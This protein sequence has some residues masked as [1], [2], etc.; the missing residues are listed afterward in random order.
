MELKK[1]TSPLFVLAT[2]VMAIITLMAIW[3]IYLLLG[4]SSRLVL[5][6]GSSGGINFVRL[7]L[8]EGSTFILLLSFVFVFFIV[9]F[10][11]D[12]KKNRSIHSFFA[13]LTHEL[14]TPLASIR[15]QSE[16]I[17][18]EAHEIKNERL[19]KLSKRLISD[20]IRLEAQMDNI[21]QLSRIERGGNLN[22]SSYNVYELIQSVASLYKDN[23]TI[24]INGN[25]EAELRCDRFAFE[26]ILK[27]LFE[28]TKNHTSTKKI[29]IDY[30]SHD[31]FTL[32]NYQD[33]GEF[34]GDVKK[35]GKLFYK[36]NSQKGSG[37]GLY[38]SN[39]LIESMNG[40][41]EIHHNRG[42]KFE[43]KFLT[44]KDTH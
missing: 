31:Q 36:F 7:I 41:L 5:L 17:N 19:E 22:I 12:M 21:L 39:K 8:W 2:I 9:L 4:M 10:Y 26:I 30:K 35:L 27:N 3:W 1:K 44:A 42:L 43:L 11:K 13:S 32:I 37:I 20:T 24:I 38:L 16:V 33:E 25:K 28:N 6:E 34:L 18:E 23:F 14:K 15:L 40:S 29:E